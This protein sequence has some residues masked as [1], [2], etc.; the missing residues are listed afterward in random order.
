MFCNDATSSLLFNATDNV[1][2]F[3]FYTVHFKML[4]CVYLW[5]T[6]FIYLNNKENNINSLLILFYLKFKLKI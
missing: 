4:Y 2:H 1:Y 3:I 6:V 5:K